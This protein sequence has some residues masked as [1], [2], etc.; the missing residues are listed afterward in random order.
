M[1]NFDTEEN[2]DFQYNKTHKKKTNQQTKQNRNSLTERCRTN[3][4]SLKGLGG[5]ETKQVK[6]IKK[7]KL[8]SM[9]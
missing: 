1:E 8:P 3:L 7:Y 4:W 5:V 6:G 2:D 9:K